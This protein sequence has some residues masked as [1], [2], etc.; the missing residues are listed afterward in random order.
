MEIGTNTVSP[1]FENKRIFEDFWPRRRTK[2][3]RKSHLDPGEIRDPYNMDLVAEQEPF[4]QLRAQM[5][6]GSGGDSEGVVFSSVLK[7]C[8]LI[9]GGPI[10]AFFVTKVALLSML[11]GWDENAISTNVASA[12]VAVIVLHMALG[13]FIFRAYFSDSETSKIKIG[14]KD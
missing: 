6:E 1:L 14:K 4:G 2:N 8:I 13:L 3:S 12:V 10:L 9:L 7:Y 11:L 5:M